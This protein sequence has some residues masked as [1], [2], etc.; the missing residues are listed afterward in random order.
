MEKD[1]KKKVISY[2]IRIV[3]FVC[4]SGILLISLLFSNNLN[5]FIN[6]KNFGLGQFNIFDSRI[7]Y[8]DVGQGDCTFI[9]L[10]NNKTAMIDTGPETSFEKVKE[11]LE[12][13][14][15]KQIDYLILTHT[16]ADHIGNAPKIFD[17]FKVGKVYIPKVYSNYEIENDLCVKDFNTDTSLL[18][19]NTC[20]KIYEKV[21][22]KNLFYNEK[23]L[24][25][26]DSIT[27]FSF[28][29]L[30]PFKEKLDDSNA[31]SPIILY[32]YKK[33]K[34]LF[35]G[36]IDENIE[37]EF[38][39]Y[40]RDML[41]DLK[42]QVLKVAHHGSSSSTSEEFLKAVSPTIAVISC[43]KDNAYGHPTNETIN[44]LL[45][46]SCDIFRTDVS[47]SIAVDIKNPTDGS[48]VYMNVYKKY[49][50]LDTFVFEWWCFVVTIITLLFFVLILKIVIDKK[51]ELNKKKKQKLHK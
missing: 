29:F 41:T 40:Y 26:Y 6:G 50:K 22:S 9:E 42:V 31:Y 11:Y 1:N 21:E 10:P 16:D 34:A 46:N 14:N 25:I 4:C 15:R 20:K 2:I 18:W 43:G 5:E 7:H 36:D 35:V 51:W 27:G 8:I 47:D 3:I 30:S 12:K 37:K 24:N 32:E 17:T 39:T 13:L 28:K 49:E 48:G 33:I 45:E 38:L 23:N 19:E 44:K